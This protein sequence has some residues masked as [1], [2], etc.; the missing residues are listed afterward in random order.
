MIVQVDASV[1]F[2]P[3][4]GQ[5]GYEWIDEHKVLVHPEAARMLPEGVVIVGMESLKG[6]WRPAGGPAGNRAGRLPSRDA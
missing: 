1:A 6:S 5:M 4:A 3:S 2:D